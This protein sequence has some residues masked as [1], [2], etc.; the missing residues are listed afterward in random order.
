LEGVSSPQAAS[1]EVRKRSGEG[2]TALL[3]WV[4][5]TRQT[6]AVNRMT[7]GRRLF[8]EALAKVE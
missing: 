4:S 8:K 5:L 2:A 1:G 6:K 3:F 7:S